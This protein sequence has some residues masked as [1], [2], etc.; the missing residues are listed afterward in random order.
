MQKFFLQTLVVGDQ[1]FHLFHQLR[2]LG[3]FLRFFKG[4]IKGMIPAKNRRIKLFKLYI[5]IKI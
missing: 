2:Y 1:F 5:Q 4:V 3:V